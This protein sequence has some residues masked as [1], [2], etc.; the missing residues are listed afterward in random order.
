MKALQEVLADLKYTNMLKMLI[1][2]KTMSLN[3]QVYYDMYDE[4]NDDDDDDDEGRRRLTNDGPLSSL[5]SVFFYLRLPRFLQVLLPELLSMLFCSCW[6][7]KYVFKHLIILKMFFVS[8][9]GLQTPAPSQSEVV[10]KS[11]L[12]QAEQYEIVKG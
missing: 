4:N 7:I 10:S 8:K 3:F 9:L 6:K 2:L 5:L 1:K 11:M 12:G